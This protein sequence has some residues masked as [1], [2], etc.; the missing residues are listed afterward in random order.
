MVARV[1]RIMRSRVP[2]RI[3]IGI[4]FTWHSSE[5]GYSL[6]VKWKLQDEIEAQLT[7]GSKLTTGH[8]SPDHVS[9]TARPR[10]TVWE[11]G[12]NLHTAPGHM[13]D[14]RY[15]TRNCFLLYQL[16]SRRPSVQSR[17]LRSSH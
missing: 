2:C 6:H 10:K 12:T 16:T 7:R 3:W 4:S 8:I 1:R 14:C 5:H 13:R 17:K 15:R 9:T 11:S